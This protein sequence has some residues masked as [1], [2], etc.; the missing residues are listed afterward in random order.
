MMAIPRCRKPAATTVDEAVEADRRWFAEH[1]D[2][3]AYIREFCPG[4]FYA[5]E[6]PDLP[7]GFRYATLVTVIH[8][9]EGVA[10]GR[11]RHC[12]GWC[13][14]PVAMCGGIVEAAKH[15]GAGGGGG[16]GLPSERVDAKG[17]SLRSD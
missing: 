4:E 5:A 16:S 11:Y 15:S 1:P 8:R 2:Q 14:D 12:I 3:D 17:R 13:D 6:L 9:T 10:D 7:P